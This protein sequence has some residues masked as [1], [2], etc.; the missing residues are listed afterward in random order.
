MYLYT[1]IYTYIQADEQLRIGEDG[2]LKMTI[3]RNK[4]IKQIAKMSPNENQNQSY[5][6]N[7]SSSS[8]NVKKEILKKENYIGSYVRKKFGSNFFFGLIVSFDSPFYKIVYEDGDEEE[9]AGGDISK[10]YW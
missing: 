6:S 1:Y 2:L 8:T 5:Q 9:G 3:E 7:H 4:Y 10:I